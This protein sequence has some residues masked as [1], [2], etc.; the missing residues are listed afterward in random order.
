M[1]RAIVYTLPACPACVKLKQE[2]VRSG[3][4]FE[5]RQ[6]NERQAWL[7]EALEYGDMVPIVVYSDG[8]VQVGH[9]GMIG[10]CIA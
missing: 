7:D 2:L 8:Q 6:V 3:I 9:A 5:E 4:D 10:C 1:S